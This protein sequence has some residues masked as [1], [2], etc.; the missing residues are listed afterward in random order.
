MR[1]KERRFVEHKYVIDFSWSIEDDFISS[2]T[3]SRHNK[4]CIKF[5][6]YRQTT[7]ISSQI[8]T[9]LTSNGI[10]E[11]DTVDPRMSSMECTP[12]WAGFLKIFDWK[13]WREKRDDENSNSKNFDW[14]NEFDGMHKGNEFSLRGWLHLCHTG[15]P[16]TSHLNSIVWRR[17]NTNEIQFDFYIRRKRNMAWTSSHTVRFGR[18]IVWLWPKCGIVWYLIAFMHS[19][20]RAR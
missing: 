5:N 6:K 7:N 12:F 4:T 10:L 16:I 2:R 8:G 17:N 19:H 9:C 11:Y 20:P 13:D 14:L 18:C 1:K 15:R 3:P